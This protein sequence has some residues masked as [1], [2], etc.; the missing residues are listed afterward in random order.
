MARPQPPCQPALFRPV[1]TVRRIPGRL[2]GLRAQSDSPV[3]LLWLRPG[4]SPSPSQLPPSPLCILPLSFRPQNDQPPPRFPHPPLPL[5]PRPPPWLW[6]LRLAHP[7]LG[8][9]VGGG[10]GN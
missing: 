7:V 3:P 2:Q 1:L 6:H 10:R 4:P 9:F 5:P 8:L